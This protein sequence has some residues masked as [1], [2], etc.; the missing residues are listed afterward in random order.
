MKFPLFNRSKKLKEKTADD[1]NRDN[2]IF[3]GPE[4][5]PLLRDKIYKIMGRAEPLPKDSESNRKNRPR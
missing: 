5:K 1:K 4:K 3:K 2:A